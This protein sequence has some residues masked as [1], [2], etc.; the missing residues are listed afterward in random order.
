[1]SSAPKE[2][3]PDQVA[4]ANPVFK[5][6]DEK[7][8]TIFKSYRAQLK[9]ILIMVAVGILA[10]VSF[11]GMILT[12]GIIFAGFIMYWYN[13]VHIVQHFGLVRR[14]K[15]VLAEAGVESTPVFARASSARPKAV[16]ALVV[17]SIPGF[18]GIAAISPILTR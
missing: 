4:S 16:I 3:R 9:A 15:A 10:F 11:V 12:F 14:Y 18:L 6:L 1:M 17:A 5:E 13:V 7:L 8:L 2:L